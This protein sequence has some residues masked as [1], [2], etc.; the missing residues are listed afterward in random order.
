MSWEEIASFVDPSIPL[1]DRLIYWQLRVWQSHNAGTEEIPAIYEE[2]IK[3]YVADFSRPMAWKASGD[4]KVATK[5]WRGL[6]PAFHLDQLGMCEFYVKADVRFFPKRGRWVASSHAVKL[7][8]LYQSFGQ[9]KAYV[10][11]T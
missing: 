4:Q 5:K 8:R 7:G 9:A 11:M 2:L 10:R 3:K 6:D 1:R